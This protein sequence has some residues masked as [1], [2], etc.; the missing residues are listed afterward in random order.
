MQSSSIID[1]F[2]CTIG[3]FDYTI[4]DVDYTIEGADCN[5]ADVEIK[6]ASCSKP[7]YYKR[8]RWLISTGNVRPSEAHSHG[9]GGDVYFIIAHPLQVGEIYAEDA[10]FGSYAH[11]G[12]TEVMLCIIISRP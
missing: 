6:N 7:F 10:V 1:A 5:I 3:G 4:G 8:H 11:R 2:D 12:P 9:E